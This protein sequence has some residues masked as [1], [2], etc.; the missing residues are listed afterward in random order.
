MQSLTDRYG[1]HYWHI[2]DHGRAELWRHMNEA[3][4]VATAFL[5]KLGWTVVRVDRDKFR[6]AYL[7]K[8]GETTTTVRRQ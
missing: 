5:E 8:P 3:Q 6:E 4:K 7:E 2:A 1:F